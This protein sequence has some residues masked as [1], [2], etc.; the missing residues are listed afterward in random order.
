MKESEI[1][2]GLEIDDQPFA[3][4]NLYSQM[5]MPIINGKIKMKSTEYISICAL[6]KREIISPNIDE[7]SRVNRTSTEPKSNLLYLI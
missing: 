3:G 6:S 2:F 1:N 5:L 7:F 4:V